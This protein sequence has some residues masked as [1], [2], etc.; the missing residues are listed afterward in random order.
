MS[1]EEIHRQVLKD[2][3]EELKD[4]KD[5]TSFMETA[6]AV[7]AVFHQDRRMEGLYDRQKD[8]ISGF[9]GLW[10]HCADVAYHLE[11]EWKKANGDAEFIDCVDSIVGRMFDYE[12]E[13]GHILDGDDLEAAA[14]EVI[15][16]VQGPGHYEE[17]FFDFYD[18]THRSL[19][20]T[21]TKV[22]V[23]AYE[24]TL[25][26]DKGGQG[27]VNMTGKEKTDSD[28][29]VVWSIHSFS[30]KDD[31]M[32]VAD[33]DTEESAIKVAKQITGTKDK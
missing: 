31:W 22:R 9:T 29:N 14:C 23:R 18:Q 6:S 4:Q 24:P 25:R 32:L 3:V 15:A 11:K 21:A 12:S 26:L 30:Q 33:F 8:V 7:S 20:G 2:Y 1:D 17:Y 28:H 10:R 5:I 27:M 19:N 16:E 13:W